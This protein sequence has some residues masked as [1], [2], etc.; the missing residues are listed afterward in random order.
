MTNYIVQ[1]ETTRGWICIH[2]GKDLEMANEWLEF[3]AAEHPFANVRLV[4]EEVTHNE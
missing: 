4:T 2:Q 1:W 3:Y